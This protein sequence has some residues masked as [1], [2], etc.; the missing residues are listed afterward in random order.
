MSI[1][2]NDLI[3]DNCLHKQ[4]QINIE[5]CEKC[6]ESLGAPNVN[7]V[8]SEAE[9]QALN[10]RYQ[11]A[12]KESSAKGLEKKMNLFKAH[13]ET[14][15][16]AVINVDLILLS[17]WLGKS[18]GYKSYHRAV[19]SGLRQIAQLNNDRKRTVIDSF[20][21]GTYGRDLIFAA[22]S[23]DGFGLRSY[24]DCHVVLDS[25]AISKRASLLEEN[26][27]N[28]VKKHNI[29]LSDPIAP[30]GFRSTWEE[31][32]KLVVAKVG[33]KINSTSSKDDFDCY[34]MTNTGDRDKDEYVEVLIYKDLT[35][36]AVDTVR[37]P[38]PKSAS[39]K[40]YAGMVKSK[41]PGQVSEI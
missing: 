9:K 6:G 38:R 5:W 20:I 3:C 8:S 23:L 17:E 11:D 18:G 33:T 26:S 13:F 15:V 19:E 40:V 1:S 37:I 4:S 24:G 7:E 31:K 36:F 28:F 32:L 30:L 16:K 14:N 35:R 10:Q 27:F 39:D 22:L 29:S 21:C 2:G 25:P 41:L 34:V 12:I